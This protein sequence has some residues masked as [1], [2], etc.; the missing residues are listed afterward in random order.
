LTGA[1]ATTAAGAITGALAGGL[2][3]AL[4]SLG[5]PEDRA[6]MYEERIK[7]GG[8]LLGVEVREEKAEE[9]TNVLSSEGAADITRV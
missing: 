7:S 6:R 4:T 8:V 5:L 3:G 9:V 2:L 1:A